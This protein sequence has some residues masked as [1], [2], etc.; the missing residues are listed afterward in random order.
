MN[1]IIIKQICEVCGRFAEIDETGVCFWCRN[2]NKLRIKSRTKPKRSRS[3]FAYDGTARFVS[4][5][6][7]HQDTLSLIGLIPPDITAVVGVARSGMAVATLVSMMLHKPLFTIRQTLGDVISCGNGWRLAAHHVE[8]VKGKVVIV[9]D[10]V[11][12][13]NSLRAIEHVVRQT[14]PNSMTASVYVN[15]SAHKKPDAWVHDLAWPHLLEWNLFNSILSPNMACDF[16]GILCQDCQPGQDDDGERY[17]DFIENARP[18]YTPRRVPIPCVITARIEKYRQPTLAWLKRHGITVHNLIM[19]PAKTLAERNADDVSAW[20]AK[21]YA[22]WNNSH[23]PRPAPNGFIESDDRQARRIAKLTG[24]LTICPASESVYPHGMSIPQPRLVSPKR[25][26]TN[27]ISLPAMRDDPPNPKSDR[28]VICVVGGEMCEKEFA[29]TGPLMKRY[30]ERCDADFIA[31]HGDQCP[32]WPLGNKYR[33]HPFLSMYSQT[34]YL[35]ADVLVS[36]HAPDIFKSVPCGEL[37]G[38]DEYSIVLNLFQDKL[39][40]FIQAESDDLC[41]SQGWKRVVRDSMINTGVLLV[42]REL[43]DVYSPLIQPFPKNWLSD[44]H[45][46]MIGMAHRDRKPCLLTD[47]WHHLFSETDFWN[48]DKIKK[49]NFIHFAGSHPHSYRIDLLRRFVSGN[50]ERIEPPKEATWSPKW[51]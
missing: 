36:D 31:L 25:E 12:T 44:Q 9:D 26:A 7:L 1:A 51:S 10:T 39:G 50:F 13:G 11:M 4:L 18:L 33:I 15:P 37:A 38:R 19:H 17:L 22:R 8:P 46:A 49:A 42:P 29:I 48:V 34:L 32:H 24:L 27:R 40:D 21:H 3:P 23:R 28:L 2:K 14:F 47:E 45:R 5:R 20:K 6:Q 16:D 35:D 30:S 41:D 43:A